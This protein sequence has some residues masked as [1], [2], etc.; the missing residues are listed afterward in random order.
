MTH[1][2]IDHSGGIRAYA[3]KGATIVAHESIVPFL[4]TVLSRPKTIRPDSLAK[5]GNLTPNIEAVNDTKSLTDGERTVELR[6]I[7][8]PHV[9]G[10]LVAFLPAEK[11]LFVSDLFTPGTPI[12]AGNTDGIANANA[13][14]TALTTAKLSVDRVVGGHGDIAR[15]QELGKAS[16][17]AARAGS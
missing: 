12:D 13:L 10:M 5:A 14:H 15:F 1:F 7:P 2:H 16:A 8:N 11:L 4:K 3:A 17:L 9:K 6:E